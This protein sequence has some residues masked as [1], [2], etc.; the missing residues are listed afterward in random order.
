MGAPSPWGLGQL[1][2]FA[3]IHMS[4]LETVYSHP[5]RPA[6]HIHNKVLGPSHQGPS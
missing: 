5:L 3:K 2:R 6:P 4:R 1:K